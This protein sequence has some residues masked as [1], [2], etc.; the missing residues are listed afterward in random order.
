MQVNS[1]N[2]SSD[3]YLHISLGIIHTS[4]YKNNCFFS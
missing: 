4:A 3:K 2:M 1:M